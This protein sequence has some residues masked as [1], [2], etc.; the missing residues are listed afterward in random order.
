MVLKI[1]HFLIAFRNAMRNGVRC[2]V[3]GV[4][5]KKKEIK[6]K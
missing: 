4:R 5:R 3:E 6:N 2:A 1:Q